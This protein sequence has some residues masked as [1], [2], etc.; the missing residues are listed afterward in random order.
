MWRKFN[1]GGFTLIE[2]SIALLI[3]FSALATFIPI[4]TKIYLERIAIHEQYQ[5]LQLLNERLLSWRLD[6]IAPL[7]TVVSIN[8]TSYR[9]NSSYSGSLELTLC[10]EWV[11]RNNRSYKQ[12]AF[13]KK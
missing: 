1:S 8:E 4:M 11:G 6:H 2:V 7:D 9:L 12:C 10:L 5:A 13:A 3:L